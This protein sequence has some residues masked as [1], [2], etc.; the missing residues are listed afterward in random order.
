MRQV[1]ERNR[2][3]ILSELSDPLLRKNRSSSESVINFIKG[4]DYHVT[5]PL[6]QNLP[7]GKRAYG[8]IFCVPTA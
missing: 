3:V 1:L 6:N 8:D 5:D 7:P 2:P 4:Y